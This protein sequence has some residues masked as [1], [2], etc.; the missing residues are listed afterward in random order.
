[1]LYLGK[2]P[3]ILDDSVTNAKMADN[4]INTSE[5]VNLAVQTGKINTAAVTDAKLAS[6]AVTT[7][8]ITDANVT[9]AKLA[10]EAVSEAK[11][12]AGNAPTNDYVSTAASGQPGGL[13]WSQLSSLPGAATRELIHS[14]NL[15]N[16]SDAEY[17][18]GSTFGYQWEIFLSL[19]SA[20]SGSQL[21]MNY[22][23]ADQNY[24]SFNTT[25][26]N[27]QINYNGTTIQN[28]NAQVSDVPIVNPNIP[29]Y[30][31]TQAHSTLN[32]HL[33]LYQDRLGVSGTSYRRPQLFGRSTVSND[34]NTYF[35]THM[36]QVTDQLRYIKFKANSGNIHGNIR[37]FRIKLGL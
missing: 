7:V 9:Q 37:I 13:I 28:T 11:L 33:F 32:S 5:L 10:G 14:S 16:A 25:Y 3:E 4:A 29:A 30:N 35:T 19:Q 23:K 17:D 15:N 22:A 27:H 21:L 8:K 18:L 20:G 36:P 2:Q 1:M 24:S 12:H 34:P 6:N 31:S 26:G